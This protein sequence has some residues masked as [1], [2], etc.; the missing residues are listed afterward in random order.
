VLAVVKSGLEVSLGAL[1]AEP[2]PPAATSEP[3]RR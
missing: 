1:L 3:S 2:A